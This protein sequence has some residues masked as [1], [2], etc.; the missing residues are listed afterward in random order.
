MTFTRLYK[1]GV[2]DLGL[3]SRVRFLFHT[4]CLLMTESVVFLGLLVYTLVL[5]PF[6][7]G[8]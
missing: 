8:V 7:N 6:A 4:F 1:Q 2:E 3:F 5:S